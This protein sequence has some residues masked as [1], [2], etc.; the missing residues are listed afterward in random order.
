M[1]VL[2][3]RNFVV[4]V[5]TYVNDL[6]TIAD[7]DLRKASG[8]TIRKD[9]KHVWQVTVPANDSATISYQLRFIDG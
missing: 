9:G 8:R 7:S 6:A 5:G 3:Y 2:D 1:T 4:F